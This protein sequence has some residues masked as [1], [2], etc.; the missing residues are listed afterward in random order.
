MKT[1]SNI[2]IP[3]VQ[4]WK[5][6][7]YAIA[8]NHKDEGIIND[9]Q[10]YS[11]DFTIVDALTAEAALYAFTRQQQNTILDN[12]V[13]ENI[14]VDRRPAIE[15]KPVFA[16]KAQSTIFPILPSTGNLKRGEIYSYGNGAVLVVQ[17]HARTIYAPELTPALFSFYREVTEGREWI[18]GEAIVIN[19]TRTYNGKTYKCLQAHQSQ[20]SW[21]PE[22]T[23]GNLW[24]VVVT[25][26]AWTVGVAY[27]VNDVVTYSGKSYKCLQAH[28]SQAG[29]TPTAVPALWKVI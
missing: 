6:G 24:S 20:E 13:I 3:K 1:Q 23:I 11:A 5:E 12:K 16:T 19:A 15:S 2:P 28:T 17:D 8:I 29:W 7:Q 10:V 9:Q 4:L 22:L 25:T 21:N 18:K 27:K 14:E 26:S